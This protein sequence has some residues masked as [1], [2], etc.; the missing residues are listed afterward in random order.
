MIIITTPIVILVL[1]DTT[2][3]TMTIIT[4]SIIL[5]TITINAT[6]RFSAGSIASSTSVAITSIHILIFV[7]VSQLQDSITRAMCYLV[8]LQDYVS[9]GPSHADWNFRKF[10]HMLMA[11]IIFLG[12]MAGNSY[13]ISIPIKNSGSRIATLTRPLS[14]Q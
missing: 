5:V 8:K 2:M 12:T 10:A 11:G 6:G 7:L 9:R 4:I 14:N 3:I 1:L 13:N